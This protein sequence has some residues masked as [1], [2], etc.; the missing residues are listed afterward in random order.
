MEQNLKQDLK[1]EQDYV[2]ILLL[3]LPSGFGDLTQKMTRY[4]YTHVALSLDDSYEHF[5]AFSR[6]RA[7]TPPVSGYIEEKRIYYTLGENIPIYT[8]IFQVPVSSV[9]LANG[10]A[11]LEQTRQDIEIMYNLINMVLIPL[12]GGAPCH[13]AYNCGEF[14]ALFLE[15]CGI[16]LHRPY[17]NYVPKLFNE[18]LAEYGIFEGTLDNSGTVNAD[19][20]FFHET[21]SLVYLDRFFHIVCELM[22]R[23]F[24]HKVSSRFRSEKVRLP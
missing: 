24:F 10:L 22:Y 13:K 1:Q 7:K 18:L 14:I 6:L 2:Y 3:Y 12:F 11:F 19:D 23:Q 9:G 17:Y 15:A 16:P 21:P 5:Y 4:R 8:K 20:N